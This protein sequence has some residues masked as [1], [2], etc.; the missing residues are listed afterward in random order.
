MNSFIYIIFSAKHPKCRISSTTVSES[1]LVTMS[2]S[3]VYKGRLA[4]LMKWQTAEGL[5]IASTLNSIQFGSAVRLTYTASLVATPDLNGIQFQCTTYFDQLN[6]NS[7][8]TM[9]NC[10]K[11]SPVPSSASNIPTYSYS[12]T[13]PALFVS[14][15][16]GI[17]HPLFI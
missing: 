17:C 12:W 5:T 16:S 2:C 13:S 9:C 7:S 14:G 4:P 10:S 8:D 11:K 6:S 1:D 15:T 3:V